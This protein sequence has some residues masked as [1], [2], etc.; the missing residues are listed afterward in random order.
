M[1]GPLPPDVNLTV[2]RHMNNTGMDGYAATAD[3]VIT[4]RKVFEALVPVM[5]TMAEQMANV[6]K[7]AV[8]AFGPL[9]DALPPADRVRLSLRLSRQGRGTQ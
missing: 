3:L 5:Q 1:K 9:I 4:A 8:R 7:A 6:A 2:I